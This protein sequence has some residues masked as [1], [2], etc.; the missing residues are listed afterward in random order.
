MWAICMGTLR[1]ATSSV[2]EA[3]FLQPLFQDLDATLQQNSHERQTAQSVRTH[4]LWEHMG[5]PLLDSICIRY[6]ELT[7]PAGKNKLA[8]GSLLGFLTT[9]QEMANLP[10]QRANA[11]KVAGFHAFPVPFT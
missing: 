8:K 2:Y 10:N 11:S 4:I 5:S 3:S 1:V 6:G 9:A 7:D